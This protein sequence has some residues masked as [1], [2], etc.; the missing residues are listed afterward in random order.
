MKRKLTLLFGACLVLCVAG[1]ALAVIRPSAVPAWARMNPEKLPAWARFGEA[2]HPKADD[3]G[4]F[5]KEHGV[6]EKFCTLCHP[7][8]KDKLLLCK[9]HG[10]IPEDI[11][12]LCHPEAAKKYDLKMCKEHG[13]PEEFCVKCGKGPEAALNLPDDG[14]CGTHNKPEA[15]CDECLKDPKSHDAASTAVATRVCRLPLPTVRLKSA[16]LVRQVGIRT[17]EAV[18]ESHAHKLSANAETAYDANRYAEVSPRVAGFLREV[19]VDLGKSVRPGEVLAIVDSAEISSAKT[20]YLTA[21]SAIQLAQATFNRT[22]ALTASGSIAGKQEL[23]AQTALNQAQAA[24]MDTEQRLRNLGFSDA[25]LQQIAK[26]K[27]TR[28]FLDVVA[29]IEGTV[30]VRHAVKGEAVKSDAQLFAVADTSKVWLWIDVYESDIASVA[31][32]QAVTFTISGTDAPVF[33]GTVTWVGAEVNQQSRTTRIR[34]ELANPDGRLRANQFGRADIQVGAEHKAVV[35]PKAAVQRKD[36]VDL[37]FLPESEAGVYR[38][39]RVT[40]KATDRNDF[41]EVTWGLK[42]GQKVVTNGAFLLKTEIMKGA[43][44]A[45]CCE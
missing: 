39:Q 28:N 34:A 4:L 20:Q 41:L 35:V 26:V 43:I 2:K 1:L 45:G 31:P 13:L 16:K 21:Q 11:C 38:P 12:T 33:K 24:V 27:D 36:N 10:G 37:V 22:K 23:E 7:D 25:Q 18:L 44:G 5:C 17:A 42:A 32:G 15:T 8:L 30:V 19:K 6:P 3:A 40:T 14:W 9:E 29:P